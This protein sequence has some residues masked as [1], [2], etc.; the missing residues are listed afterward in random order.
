MQ[1]DG[2]SNGF[3]RGRIVLRRAM[4]ACGFRF[5]TRQHGSVRADVESDNLEDRLCLAYLGITIRY[6]RH[7]VLLDVERTVIRNTTARSGKKST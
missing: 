7:T 3:R 6:Y 2:T 5:R 4:F 1:H